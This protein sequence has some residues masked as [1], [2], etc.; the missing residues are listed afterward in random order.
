[1]GFTFDN[2]FAEAAMTFN[3]IPQEVRTTP[4]PR[5]ALA[6]FESLNS[7]VYLTGS[8][9]FGTNRPT[10]DVDFFIEYSYEV[11]S[12]LESNG[13]KPI[14]NEYLQDVN[15]WRV[16]RKHLASF[17]IDVQLVYSAKNKLKVQNFLKQTG[18]LKGVEGRNVFKYW[19]ATY[20]LIDA[21]K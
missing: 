12:W 6:E 13:F 7:P 17:W 10:S 18:M 4:A 15:L 11:E 19:N 21:N 2:P 1:M 16:Y 9:F 3:H 14:F 8:W 5:L 20:L